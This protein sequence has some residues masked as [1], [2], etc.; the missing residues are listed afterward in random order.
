MRWLV[1]VVGR[2]RGE[3][4]ALDRPGPAAGPGIPAAGAIGVDDRRHPQKLAPPVTDLDPASWGGDH[5]RLCAPA[6]RLG[7]RRD[8]GVARVAR[9]RDRRAGADPGPLPDVQ[10]HR[11]RPRAPGGHAGRGVD[12]VPEHH[13]HPASRPGSPATWRSSGASGPTSAGTRRSW[14][15]TPTTTPTASAGTCPPSPPPPP[16]TRSGFN[17]F[18][19]GKRDGQPGDAVYFQGHAAPGMYARAFLEHR[20]DESQLDRFRRELS[21][22]DGDGG[23]SRW[24]V[25]LPAPVAHARVLGVPDGVDGPG[26]DQLDLPRPLQPLPREPPHRRHQRHPGLVLPGRRRVRRA[27][28]AGI[29]LAGRPRAARQPD[30]GDQLQPAAAGRAGPGQRQGHPGA[31]GHL[32]RRRLE[33]DQGHLGF[34][35][36]RAAG[37]RRR[38]RAAAPDEHHRRRRVP[39]LRGRVGRLHPRALLRPRPPPARPGRAPE[40]RRAA[41]T[42][43]AVAT[44][45]RRSTPPTRRPPSRWAPPP[46][47]WPRPSRAG[48]WAPTSRPATPPTRSRR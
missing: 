32:P 19:R 16:S 37:P 34:G 23:R 40:R 33:R 35:V 43:P 47:S 42:C 13:P 9:R 39:A 24:P 20:L 18:F 31:R 12:P 44:T 10:A 38:R 3:R 5:R 28:D 22:E 4:A 17:H 1:V 48:R 8:G 15:S 36:G 26:P 6:A 29:D 11:A 30:L 27:R 21:D 41:R 7:P 46:S 2:A 14:W 25:E 45:T